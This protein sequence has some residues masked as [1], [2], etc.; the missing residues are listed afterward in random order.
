MREQLTQ[1][2]SLLFAGTENCED[3][4]QEILQNTLDRYDDLIA[5]G[6]APEAAYRLAIIGIGDITEIL[7]TQTYAPAATQ[8]TSPQPMDEGDDIHKKRMRATGIAL[9]IMCAIPLILLDELFGWAT[10]GLCCTLIMV[11]IA[12]VL[13]ILGAKKEPEEREKAAETHNTSP[14]R[15][16]ISSLIWWTM[17]I[18]Y[19]VLS[20]V[21]GAWHVTWLLFPIGGAVK[22][23]CN[24]ILDLLEVN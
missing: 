16:S 12:T 11:A 4:Y 10:L 17:L 9:Y 22:G 21:T 2:V 20:F 18:I 24:A 8:Y 3:V 23:L 14:L 6:K 7:G 15:K 1:Y 13:M 19:F 5:Q